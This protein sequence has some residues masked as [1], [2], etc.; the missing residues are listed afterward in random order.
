VALD[1]KEQEHREAV[2]PA[3]LKH[4]SES[5]CFLISDSKESSMV[6]VESTGLLSRDKV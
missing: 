1:S 5:V 3:S 6:G 4:F 2:T